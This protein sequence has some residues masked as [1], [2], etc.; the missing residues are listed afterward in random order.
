MENPD[1]WKF[2]TEDEEFEEESD[3]EGID[4]TIEETF[5]QPPARFSRIESNPYLDT[6]PIENLEQDL[7]DIPS[8][9]QNQEENEQVSY[10]INAPEYTYDN[11]DYDTPRQVD[12]Q[13]DSTGGALMRSEESL[14][15]NTTPDFNF[16]RWQQANVGE[17]PGIAEREGWTQAPKDFQRDNYL[18][19]EKKNNRPPGL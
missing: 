4:G 9:R 2:E 8:Q 14:R 16:R 12:T 11:T 5:E 15:L 17:S 10:T 18:P 7:Q 1:D 13:R 19:F 6:E 3:E